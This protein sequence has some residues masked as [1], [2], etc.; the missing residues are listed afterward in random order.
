MY[1]YSLNS[2]I[3]VQNGHRN[4]NYNK[5]EEDIILRVARININC[6]LSILGLYYTKIMYIF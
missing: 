5:I 1:I 3:P 4:I 6:L 2:L